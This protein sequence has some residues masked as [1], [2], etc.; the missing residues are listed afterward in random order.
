MRRK[1]LLLLGLCV[2]A[3]SY[4]VKIED[5]YVMKTFDGGQIYFIEPFEVPGV[6]KQAKP[7]SADITYLTTSDSVTMNISVWTLQELS[8][9][10][11]VLEGSERMTF[12][13]FQTFFIER[14]KKWWLHRY[15]FRYPLSVLNNLYAQSVP[16]TLSVYS[17]GQA[18]EYAYTAKAW[19]KERDWLTQILHIIATNKR[20]Y[21]QK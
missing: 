11:I 4:A 20:L 13:E 18:Y 17:H 19:P 8:A 21:Q 9:D 5:R 16:F 2:C 1:I 12:T 6:A 15:S 7:M 3:L 14:E 10:S